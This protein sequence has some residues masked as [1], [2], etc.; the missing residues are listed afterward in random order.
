MKFQ[1]SLFTDIVDGRQVCLYKDC[2]GDLWMA[3]H[4]FSFRTQY[5][6]GGK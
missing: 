2:Y 4:Q 5:S 3:N 1:T 6:G